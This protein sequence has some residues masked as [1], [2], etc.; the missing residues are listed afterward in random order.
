M[1]YQ[2]IR[3][4]GY[5]LL[6]VEGSSY[7][8]PIHFHKRLCIGKVIFG[9]KIISINNKE[10]KISKGK[11]FIIPP[12]IAHSCKAGRSN[13]YFVFSLNYNEINDFEILSEGASFLKIGWKEMRL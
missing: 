1:I 4:P 13:G 3:R 9:E 10:N 2:A 6:R 7:D 11:I 5:E 8:F 12:Y